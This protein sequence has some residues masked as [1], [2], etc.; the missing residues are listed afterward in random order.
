MKPHW[1][2]W[3]LP[4]S[5]SNPIHP[6]DFSSD[7]SGKPLTR[8]KVLSVR[9]VRRAQLGCKGKGRH[10]GAKLQRDV[11][12][13]PSGQIMG[14]TFDRWILIL[15]KTCWSIHDYE[16]SINDLDIHLFIIHSWSIMSINSYKSFINHVFSVY[17]IYHT[18]ILS[19]I[20]HLWIIYKSS[21]RC[22]CI[23]LSIYLSIY[24][25]TY[26][27]T[28]LPTYLSIQ[29]YACIEDSPKTP[30]FIAWSPGRDSIGFGSRSTR[31]ITRWT[32]WPSE[33][34][35]LFFLEKPSLGILKKL[36]YRKTPAFPETW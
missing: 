27:P 14:E 15:G 30:D 10:G 23:H 16:S 21:T 28:Y 9:R 24:L 29:S 36:E 4:Y 2:P 8:R 17:D 33:S 12:R 35:P 1:I 7:A 26:L 5:W 18:I 3:K 20:N 32:I 34:S 31:S 22:M 6:R 11:D 19:S 25:S 13:V